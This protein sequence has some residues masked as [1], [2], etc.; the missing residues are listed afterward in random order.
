MNERN[1]QDTEP[2][3]GAAARAQAEYEEALQRVA[4]SA[5]LPPDEFKRR[6]HRTAEDLDQQLTPECLQLNEIELYPSFRLLPRRRKAHVKTCLV[7]QEFLS[8]IEPP[9]DETKTFIQQAMNASADIAGERDWLPPAKTSWFAWR[10]AVAGAAVALTILLPVLALIAQSGTKGPDARVDTFISNVVVAVSPDELEFA[11]QQGVVGPLDSDVSVVNAAERVLER[12]LA[13][14]PTPHDSPALF[15]VG[16]DMLQNLTPAIKG[17]VSDTEVITRPQLLGLSKLYLITAREACEARGDEV[18]KE[19]FEALTKAE[20]QQ[21]QSVQAE[22][23]TQLQSEVGM[24]LA[25]S[26][27]DAAHLQ[28]CDEYLRKYAQVRFGLSASAEPTRVVAVQ[29]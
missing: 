9:P 23:Y 25:V 13:H 10:P 14:E 12:Q 26:T 24:L 6:V 15:I 4:D 2:K 27:A 17:E 29:R 18:L 28:I 16:N 22:T 7:C 21:G 3:N 1:E 19:P 11:R 20:F 5:G 8:A